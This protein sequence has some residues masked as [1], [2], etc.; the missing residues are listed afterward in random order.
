MKR[1]APR[2]DVMLTFATR[3]GAYLADVDVAIVGDNGHVVLQTKCSGPIML[4]DFPQGGT[5]RVRA[6]HED[7]EVTRIVRIRDIQS[8]HRHVVMRWPASAPDLSSGALSS[9]QSEEAAKD[10]R[11]R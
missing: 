8:Q 2:Y 4:V 3:N 1:E 10:R 9:E 6:Q 11:G 7:H 5:Y